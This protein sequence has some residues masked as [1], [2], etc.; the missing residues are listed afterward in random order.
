MP[1]ISREGK[2]RKPG[3]KCLEDILDTNEDPSFI[4]FIEVSQKYFLIQLL[5][6]FVMGSKEANDTRIGNQTSMDLGRPTTKSPDTS[7]ETSQDPDKRAACA[8]SCPKRP[9]L[10]GVGLINA[11]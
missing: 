8:Y 11:S 6:M 10:I 3:T 9:I 4:N 1:H 7:L 2:T 5:V